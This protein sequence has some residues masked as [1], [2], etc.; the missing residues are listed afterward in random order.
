MQ[1]PI[2]VSL[3]WPSKVI[4]GDCSHRPFIADSIYSCTFYSYNSIYIAQHGCSCVIMMMLLILPYVPKVSFQ[5]LQMMYCFWWSKMKNKSMLQH[6]PLCYNVECG[7]KASFSCEISKLWT[8]LTTT[9]IIDQSSLFQSWELLR[10]HWPEGS[11]IYKRW[12]FSKLSFSLSIA[13]W[14]SWNILAARSQIYEPITISWWNP[15]RWRHLLVRCS[16]RHPVLLDIFTPWPC[17]GWSKITVP[18]ALSCGTVEAHFEIKSSN[19]VLISE[20]YWQVTSSSLLTARI[21]PK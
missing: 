18:M 20:N 16:S 14:S 7:T 21:Y 1:S 5:E 11:Q 2:I 8:V 10:Q 13:R 17:F 15:S 19:D 6:Q 3:Y 4:P 9:F 12:K